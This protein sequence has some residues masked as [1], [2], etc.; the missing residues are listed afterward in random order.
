MDTFSILECLVLLAASC[1]GLIRY[2]RLGLSFR[3]LTWSAVAVFTLT[4]IADISSDIYRT[5]ALVLQIECITQYVFYSLTYY[6]IFKNNLVKK[7][8][9]ISVVVISALFFINGVF[10]QSFNKD[11]PTNIYIPTQILYAAF[12]LLLFKEMLMYP[13][14]INI[15]KQSV[16][17]Y[18]TAIL[19]YG[20]T[21]FFILGIYNYMAAHNLDDNFIFVFWYIIIY[22]FNILMCIAL[23]TENKK[24]SP[25]DA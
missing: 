11:F 16:F 5:N 2:R 9:I 13:V 6:F 19:F 12:S 22:A 23:L 3:I 18:N 14:R 20:T 17:W 25:A 10:L 15:I 21:M 1:A 7:A 8:I 24:N 4:I